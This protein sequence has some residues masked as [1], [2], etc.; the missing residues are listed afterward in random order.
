MA[1]VIIQ[2]ETGGLGLGAVRTRGGAVVLVDPVGGVD[3][4]EVIGIT[5]IKCDARR[6]GGAGRRNGP[7]SDQRS[8]GFRDPP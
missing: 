8:S 2:R 6:A 5:P 4:P 3:D 1:G 7:A